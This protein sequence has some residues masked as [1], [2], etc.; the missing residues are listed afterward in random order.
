MPNQS[1]LLIEFSKE[2]FTF[3]SSN[4]WQFIIILFLIICRE[5]ISDLVKRITNLKYRKG[6]TEIGLEALLPVRIQEVDRSVSL[7]QEPI[8]RDIKEIEIKEK[9]DKEIDWFSNMYSALDAGNIDE[10]KSI[11][12]KY[13]AEETN[14]DERYNN[15]SFYLY[16]IYTKGKERDA[17]SE[18]ER[19]TEKAS[20]ETLM[21]KALFWLSLC[22]RESSNYKTEI[23]LWEKTLPNLKISIN[24][25]NCLE[26]L[27]YALKSD[28]RSKEGLKLLIIR[29]QE[30]EADE[31]KLII[32]KAIAAL[33]KD[34]GNNLMSA[35][36]KDKAV[37]L[38]PDDH[39]L[40]FD[41]AYSQSEASLRPLSIC[42]YST[43]IN[44]DR[45]NSTAL[46]NIGVCA[47]EQ[48]LEI[49]AYNYYKQAMDLGSTLAN[50][51][52]GYKLLAGGFHMHAEE[53]ANKGLKEK[54][55]HSNL[56]SLL[57]KINLEREAENKKWS[58]IKDKSALF[59]KN[60]RRYVDNYY[61]EEKKV[62]K[63]FSGNW[64]TKDGKEISANVNQNNINIKW[65]YTVGVLNPKEVE[66]NISGIL[67]NKSA[68][69][70][71]KTKPLGLQ[72]ALSLADWTKHKE[73]ECLSYLE[74]D[75]L[76]WHLFSKNTDDD[77]ELKLYRKPPNQYVTEDE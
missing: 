25:T 31:E 23:A 3:I 75:L 41:A 11:F 7:E 38:N 56:Y 47:A 29:L 35:L 45:E 48:H 76:T 18:L 71:Y 5:S 1:N 16:L 9:K 77:F 21:I 24:Q 61:N 14:N 74:S 72:Y 12:R 37:Q 55:P 52:L 49:K 26:Y 65:T 70:H 27:A 50:A 39:D 13:Y 15:E 30:V 8:E 46:N 68:K 67:K 54:D 34:L 58:E 32:F 17:L 53:L 10:A 62:E 36:C 6:E 64:F 33:E 57:S 40:L 44:L 59:Q 22:Y 28:Q 69:I 63:L 66:V 51:N 73:S 20:N 42:N 60:V 2:L 43:L 4:I 19:L